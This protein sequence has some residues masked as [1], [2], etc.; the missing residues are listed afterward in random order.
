MIDD[1]LN[2]RPGGKRGRERMVRVDL[3]RAI[4]Q[5]ER[6]GV[7]VGIEG[8]NAGHGAQRQIVGAEAGRRLSQ[9]VIDLGQ[10]QT[11]LQRRR[12]PDREMFAACGFVAQDTIGAMRP[13]LAAGFG[14]DQP[15]DELGLDTRSPDRCGQ[16]M[17]GRPRPRDDRNPGARQCGHEV[18][19]NIGGHL[20]IFRRR[21]DRTKRHRGPVPRRH[22]Q[23]GHRAER[24]R[25]HRLPRQRLRRRLAVAAAIRDR[26]SSEMGKA[27]AQRHIHDLD[28]GRALQ[29]FAAGAF[30]PDLAQHG[31]RGLADEGEEL[32]LQGPAGSAGDGSEF[33][34][35]P[36]AADD[37]R[38]SRPARA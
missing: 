36:V 2:M 5:F 10:P 20:P 34:Q 23:R 31:A 17:A 8:E 25:E 30:E 6:A 24:G 13:E 29:Q 22:K 27:A 12:D 11:W 4:E 9:R 3:Q 35:A 1:T 33:R 38:A 32:A 18:V 37:W 7:A 16:K 19:G 28:A 21:L 26:E 15:D 14:V